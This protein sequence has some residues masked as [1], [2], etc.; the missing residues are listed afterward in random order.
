MGRRLMSNGW[1]LGGERIWRT[2][3]IGRLFESGVGKGDD[4]GFIVCMYRSLDE[5]G[6]IFRLLHMVSECL[7]R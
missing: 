5:Q 3:G 7:N 2:E 6:E 1:C 4:G